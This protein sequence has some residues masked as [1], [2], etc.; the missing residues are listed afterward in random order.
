MTPVSAIVEARAQG[1]SADAGR[2]TVD[3]GVQP[4]LRESRAKSA[5]AGTDPV[6]D[7]I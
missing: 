5:A 7:G 6:G 4:E 1:G 2:A 3:A